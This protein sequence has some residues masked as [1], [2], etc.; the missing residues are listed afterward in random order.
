MSSATP[1]IDFSSACSPVVFRFLCCWRARTST[2]PPA[3]TPPTTT[4]AIGRPQLRGSRIVDSSQSASSA[5]ATSVSS[6]RPRSRRSLS[7]S[8]GSTG[9]SALRKSC[10][11]RLLMRRRS[12]LLETLFQL[13]DGP[14]YQH[15]GRALGAAESPRD[16]AVVHAKRESHDEGLAAIVGELRHALE[17]LLHLLALL[18][19][20]LGSVRLE[21]HAR[22]LELGH[23]PA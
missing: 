10:S 2:S 11:T 19:Q 21:Q 15:L 13:L 5:A 20:L 7:A 9:T 4:A 23:R 17:D 3:A 22:V 1:R 12:L 8:G 6:A 16:L 18:H 14:V